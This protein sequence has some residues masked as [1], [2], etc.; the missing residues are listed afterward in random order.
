MQEAQAAQ[1]ELSEMV[2]AVKE[3][4]SAI[5]KAQ[6]GMIAIDAA[7][8]A[9][10]S[11]VQAE[12]IAAVEMAKGALPAVLQM[13]SVSNEH[14]FTLQQKIEQIDTPHS[15][16]LG[17]SYDSL[18]PRTE[19]FNRTH[20]SLESGGVTTIRQLCG[21]NMSNMMMF[22]NLGKKSFEEVEAY[23]ERLGVPFTR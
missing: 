1:K 12:A 5:D 21:L 22:R 7:P 4:V 17:L 20:N 8:D 23:R 10:K 16:P 15:T 11:E 9:F 2:S 14:L 19:L 13:L 18:I 3:L 6:A